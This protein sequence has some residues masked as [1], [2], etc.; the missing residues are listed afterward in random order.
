MYIK[1]CVKVLCLP[2]NISL[3]FFRNSLALFN[4]FGRC[5][6]KDTLLK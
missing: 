3:I 2:L 5:K 1:L 6:T 4:K